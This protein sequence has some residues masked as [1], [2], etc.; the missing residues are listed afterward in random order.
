MNLMKKTKLDTK[1]N[2]CILITL[3]CRQPLINDLAVTFRR[4]RVHDDGRGISCM[5]AG[6]DQRLGSDTWAAARGRAAIHIYIY[7]YIWSI[8]DLSRL[9]AFTEF[10]NHR[11]LR[12]SCN[13]F[14]SRRNNWNG[15]AALRCDTSMFPR[16]W[17]RA[18]SVGHASSQLTRC[19]TNIME[20]L[21]ALD[22]K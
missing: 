16:F 13:H 19:R 18:P 11:W 10:E 6:L 22:S 9:F 17:P 15:I 5:Q 7:I 2:V 3:S 8:I 4:Q 20:P 21:M 12:P 1:T 14:L